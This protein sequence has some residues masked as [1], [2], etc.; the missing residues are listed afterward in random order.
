MMIMMSVGTTTIRRPM[1]ILH[2]M[3]TIRFELK[4]CIIIICI[5]ILYAF[6]GYVRSMSIIVVK[7]LSSLFLL[8]YCDSQWLQLKVGHLVNS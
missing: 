6:H 7:L 1:T 3:M 2:I 8:T 5:M 4:S